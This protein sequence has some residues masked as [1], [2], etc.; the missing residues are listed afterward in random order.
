MPAMIHPTALVAEEAQLAPDVSVGP[1]SVIE[2][3]VV[4]GAGCKIGPHV[5][6]RGKVV[7]GSG[8]TLSCGVVL[9]EDP[10]S[11]PFDQ[12]TDSGLI[13]GDNNTLREYVT[14]H[15]SMSDGGNTIL[16][17]ENFLMTNAHLGHDVVTGNGNVIASNAM[18]AGHVTLGNR[19]FIGGGAA[20]HQFLRIGDLAMVAGYGAISMDVPPFCTTQ[21]DNHLAGLNAIGLRRAGFSTD[22]RKDLKAAYR[23]LFQRGLSRADALAEADSREWSPPALQLIEAVRT[24]TK[25]GVI[26]RHR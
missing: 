18:F 12:D 9:G 6:I 8:N 25:R 16:G 20:F 26:A 24:P 7:M 3:P 10:Q 4:I 22:Q 14:I 1:F 15:R 17:D 13:L 19:A 2:G 11:I 21:R 5:Y 23:I